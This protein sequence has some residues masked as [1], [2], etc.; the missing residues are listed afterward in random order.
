MIIKES[1]KYFLSDKISSSSYYG[2][3]RSLSLIYP[4]VKATDKKIFIHIPKCA[5]KS[6]KIQNNLNLNGHKKSFQ[7][8]KTLLKINSF[9]IFRNP[10][11]R[12]C[13][14][15][16]YI[17]ENKKNKNFYNKALDLILSTNNPNDF[18]KELS[19]HKNLC[20]KLFYLEHFQP[21]FIWITFNQ[22][23]RSKKSFIWI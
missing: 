4:N 23:L 19:T 10:L 11:D 16:F 18:I 6:F 12:F 14:A 22:K 7:Y 5:G 20:N 15:Y 13:S 21:Q 8:K 1:L 9:A 3:S 17:K 2:L